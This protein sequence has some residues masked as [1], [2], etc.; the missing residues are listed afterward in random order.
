M[1]LGRRK[2][3][4]DAA[5]ILKQLDHLGAQIREIEAPTVDDEVLALARQSQAVVFSQDWELRRRA[6]KAGL[7]AF[8][9]ADFLFMLLSRE[10]LNLEDYQRLIGVLGRRGLISR[11]RMR[12]YLDL[13]ID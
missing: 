3:Y 1:Q 8:D 4:R 9:T 7:V 10:I 6:Q 5:R 2:G 11:D 13:N 12:Q